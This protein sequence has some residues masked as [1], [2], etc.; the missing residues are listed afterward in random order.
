M[1]MECRSGPWMMEVSGL[2]WASLVHTAPEIGVREAAACF[3]DRNQCCLCSEMLRTTPRA[4]WSCVAQGSWAFVFLIWGRSFLSSWIWGLAISLCSLNLVPWWSEEGRGL[5]GTHVHSTRCMQASWPS[6]ASL[7]FWELAVPKGQCYIRFIPWVA[8]GIA[9]QMNGCWALIVLPCD[10]NFKEKWY[11][12]KWIWAGRKLPI[13]G[14]TFLV[15]ILWEFLNL[16][17]INTGYSQRIIYWVNLVN[18]MSCMNCY[19]SKI[20]SFLTLGTRK[21]FF[22]FSLQI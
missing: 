20:S 6:L 15:V 8:V 10:V 13:G 3:K 5:L 7:V 1:V 19:T 11:G 14:V 9:Q 21:N 2:C 18:V 16:W 22:F 12:C 4:V 17:S